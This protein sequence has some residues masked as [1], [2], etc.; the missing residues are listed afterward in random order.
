VRLM[1][2]ID[3]ALPDSAS[4]NARSNAVLLRSIGEVHFSRRY[5]ALISAT[6]LVVGLSFA[7]T[8]TYAEEDAVEEAK[9]TTTD[10]DPKEEPTSE[11]PEDPMEEAEEGK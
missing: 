1:S 7:P 5:P 10:A 9:E 11:A 4:S 3:A 2:A 8:L 6:A